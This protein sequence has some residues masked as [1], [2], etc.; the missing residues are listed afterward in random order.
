MACI[1]ESDIWQVIDGFEIGD[2]R[3]LQVERP[4]GGEPLHRFE[5]GDLRALQ[6]ERLQGGE[7]LQRFEIGDRRT[8]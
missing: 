7:P 2:L 4:Q 8:S 3:A 6:V 1:L 5:I